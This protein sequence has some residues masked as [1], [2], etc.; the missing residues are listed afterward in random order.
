M[1]QISVEAE[2][3]DPVLVV[4]DR[5]ENPDWDELLTLLGLTIEEQTINHFTEQGGPE[6]PWPPTKRGG[7]ILVKTG[8]LKGSIGIAV[9]S[10]QVSIG[11]NV[12]YGKYHQT[13][14]ENDDGSERMP[15]RAFLGLTGEDRNEL[16][17]VLESYVERM[18]A[19]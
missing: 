11:T 3:F 6:G 1:V 15:R 18:V 4:L 2:G 9:G 19:G 12:F 13:G 17:Q 16:Q 14:T 7:T 8:T 5:L 10:M